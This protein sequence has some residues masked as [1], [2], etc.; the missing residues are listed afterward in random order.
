MGRTDC[1]VKLREDF[2]GIG[3]KKNGC[4]LSEDVLLAGGRYMTITLIWISRD[5][6]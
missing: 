1:H 4:L 5:G 3:S 6:L 2:K